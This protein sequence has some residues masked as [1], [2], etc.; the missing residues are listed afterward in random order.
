MSCILKNNCASG[1]S[2]PK[3]VL[4]FALFLS[5]M[6]NMQLPLI[7]CLYLMYRMESRQE[8]TSHVDAPFHHPE[9]PPP[10]QE[11]EHDLN[12]GEDTLTPRQVLQEMDTELDVVHDRINLNKEIFQEEL[13]LLEEKFNTSLKEFENRYFLLDKK[14]VS[15]YSFYVLCFVLFMLEMYLLYISIDNNIALVSLLNLLIYV[16]LPFNIITKLILS[17]CKFLLLFSHPGFPL[18][19]SVIA[20]ATL[21]FIYRKKFT[22]KFLSFAIIAPILF[23]FCRQIT[24]SHSKENTKRNSK[25]YSD[26]IRENWTTEERILHKY[27]NK[28]DPNRINK[29]VENVMK[30]IRAAAAQRDNN[31][32]IERKKKRMFTSSHDD[33][34]IDTEYDEMEDWDRHVRIINAVRPYLW[35]IKRQARAAGISKSKMRSI[36]EIIPSLIICVKTFKSDTSV[37]LLNLCNLMIILNKRLVVSDDM[38][39]FLTVIVTTF[40][41]VISAPK[42][43]SRQATRSHEFTQTLEELKFKTGITCDSIPK[44]LA[45]FLVTVT[46]L[47]FLSK[48]PRKN[49]F[50]SIFNRIGKFSHNFNGL[51][52]MVG[53]SSNCVEQSINFYKSFSL[54]ENSVE[55][56]NFSARKKLYSRIQE[57]ATLEQQLKLRLDPA[58]ISEIDK[59]FITSLNLST[60]LRPSEARDHNNYHATLTRLHRACITSPARGAKMRVLPVQ[61]QLFGDAGVGKT[62]LVFPLSIDALKSMPDLQLV[63][64]NFMNH[65]YFRQVGAKY[66][67]NYNGAQHHVTVIDDANQILPKICESIPFTGEIIHLANSAECPLSVA[68]V[69]NKAFALFNSR[70]IIV[71]DNNQTPDVTATISSPDAYFRRIDFSVKVMC[72]PEF[73]IEK[74]HGN[75]TYYVFDTEKLDPKTPNTEKYLFQLYKPGTNE[76]IGPILN[77]TELLKQICD[78]LEKNRTQHTVDLDMYRDYA[79]SH[80]SQDFFLYLFKDRLPNFLLYFCFVFNYT[81]LTSIASLVVLFVCLFLNYIYAIIWPFVYLFVIRRL[82]R[83]NGIPCTFPEIKDSL[84]ESCSRFKMVLVEAFTAT[85]NKLKFLFSLKICCLAIIPLI[86]FFVYKCLRKESDRKKFDELVKEEDVDEIREFI[87]KYNGRNHRLRHLQTIID[88]LDDEE[89]LSFCASNK[90]YKSEVY[91]AKTQRINKNVRSEVYDSSKQ[92]IRKNVL[93]HSYGITNDFDPVPYWR[94]SLPTEVSKSTKS[95]YLA[96]VNSQEIL[97]ILANDNLANLTVE[98]PGYP[99]RTVNILM[100]RGGI[101]VTVNHILYDC[102]DDT[103]MT[104]TCNNNTYHCSLSECKRVRTTNNEIT[105]DVVFL[106]FPRSKVRMFR[107]ITKYFITDTTTPASGQLMVT[108]LTRNLKGVLHLI[109]STGIQHSLDHF[110][111]ATPSNQ[112]S[113]VY[114]MYVTGSALA[115]GDCGAPL[116]LN[117][118]SHPHKILGFHVAGCK[119]RAY[120]LRLTLEEIQVAFR[121][122]EYTHSMV[123]EER[124]DKFPHNNTDPITPITDLPELAGNLILTD[125]LKPVYIPNE[126][127]IQ[128]SEIFE[129]LGPATTMPAMLKNT[130]DI[131][132]YK[133]NLAKYFG[134]QPPLQNQTIEIFRK[135]I[136]S[137]FGRIPFNKLSIEE[138]IIGNEVL[139]PIDRS[140]SPGYPYVFDNSKGKQKWMGKGEDWITDHPDLINAITDFESKV[141]EGLIPNFYFIDQTKDE[142]RPIEKVLAGKTRMFAIGNMV[143]TVLIRQYFSWFDSEMKKHLIDN[144]SLIGID[145]TSYDWTK[146]YGLLLSMTKGK[147]TAYAGDYTTYDGDLRR[148]LLFAVLDALIEIGEIPE[149]YH[150]S[151]FALWSILVDSQHIHKGIVYRLDHSQPSGNPWTSVI[152]TIYGLGLMETAITELLLERQPQLALEVRNKVLI[153]VYGDDNLVAFD[154]EIAEIITPTDVGLKLTSYG[155]KY[156]NDDKTTELEFK[157]VE[158]LTILKRGFAWDDELAYCF[159]PL[160]HKVWIEMMNWDKEKDPMLKREQL[161]VNGLTVQREL[162]H[163]PKQIYESVWTKGFVP[164]LSKLG[165]NVENNIPYS[166]HR[167]IIANR[168]N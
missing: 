86:V 84:S 101:G 158:D 6:F 23:L 25:S 7:V 128:K 4:V 130:K 112:S 142:R 167:A 24:L 72:N 36:I 71:T 44:V 149:E 11:F 10:Y 77:Y 73:S 141:K 87:E 57:L 12:D 3:L 66:W 47:I 70:L 29:I 93:S 164:H 9:P 1:F 144:G 33:E 119:G 129:C 59:L 157:K 103:K 127:S 108:S 27:K 48:M 52:D 165:I 118:T 98:T 96:D 116:I 65:I 35:S 124:T 22:I 160:D 123:Y 111:A 42:S 76:L 34:G 121:E 110:T 75:G 69:D 143:L 145:P 82:L 55:F 2:I 50:D 102:T 85:K 28:V 92:A 136:V 61:V 97:R 126:T 105:R 89:V 15:R 106:G 26:K 53:F 80:M 32:A 64:E 14:I 74:T 155:H 114:D 107:D 132:V 131:N 40:S 109:T 30:Q 146:L 95:Q 163:H 94:G 154:D 8:T 88:D 161:R 150:P 152:N 45:T 139:G 91:E 115:A 62:K 38:C 135:S 166:L 122:F 5:C 134:R 147:K 117:S 83:H 17:Y 41:L 31:A 78:R 43:S 46:S 125:Q 39:T 37:F 156:T 16:F 100:L 67:T 79:N 104:L 19:L 21:L 58:L 90:T 148:D 60:G 18:A 137:R 153:F 68:E 140:T 113:N 138:A 54:S 162:I 151:M 63:P 56:K 120:A 20:Y 13:R 49:D 133:Q 159:A 168:I 99:P 81:S 51:L